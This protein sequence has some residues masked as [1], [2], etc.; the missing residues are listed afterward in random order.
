MINFENNPLI[1]KTVQFSLDIIE[2]CELLEEKESLSLQNNCFVQGQALVQ[3]LLKHKIL[4]VR[5]IL[6]T[7]LK[8][9]QKNLKK[10]NIGDILC[11]HSKNYPF[12]EDL[13]AQVVEIGKIIYKILSTGLKTK[14]KH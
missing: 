7:K 14:I 9:Q 12:N 11:K 13:E 6:S 4:I 3:I 8:L 2:L 1:N 10:Q 5:K